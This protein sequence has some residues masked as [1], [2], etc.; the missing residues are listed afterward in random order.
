MAYM[1]AIIQGVASLG[2][3]MMS[4]S[5]AGQSNASNRKQAIQQMMFQERMSSTAHQREVADLKAAGLNPILSGTGGGG[6]STPAGASAHIENERG[7]GVS[8]ALDALSKVTDALLANQEAAKK[9]AETEQIKT[10]TSTKLPAES[11]LIREQ[12]NTA[13]ATQHNLNMDSHLKGMNTRVAFS[14]IAKNEEMTRMLK[15]QGLSNNTLSALN[16]MNI[17]QAAETLKTLRNQGEIS[18][19]AFGK[20]LAYIDRALSTIGKAAEIPSRLIPKG[21]K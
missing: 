17:Q 4:K 19:S 21:R 7:A 3:G 13:K 20:T 8:S 9:K 16:N 11:A 18:D 1:G 10:V 12:T 2:G 14:E 15:S 5:G 6:A